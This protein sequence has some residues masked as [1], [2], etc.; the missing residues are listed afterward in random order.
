MSL[1][2]CNIVLEQ[3]ILDALERSSDSYCPIAIKKDF[4][5]CNSLSHYLISDSR[6]RGSHN[7]ID[8]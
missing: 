5:T 1:H 4:A 8:M 7:S 3:T 2:R 6:Y